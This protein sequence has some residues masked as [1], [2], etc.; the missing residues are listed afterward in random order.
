MIENEEVDIPISYTKVYRYVLHQINYYT[1]KQKEIED[2]S[3][4]V[5]L[6]GKYPQDYHDITV[7]IEE[8]EYLRRKLKDDWLIFAYE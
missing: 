1:K 3:T 5:Y 2:N 4:E 6:L 7:K 8:W